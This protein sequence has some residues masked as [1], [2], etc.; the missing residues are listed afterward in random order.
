MSVLS[1]SRGD[2]IRLATTVVGSR[3]VGKPITAG[4]LF[5]ISVLKFPWAG[6]GGFPSI[7]LYCYCFASQGSQEP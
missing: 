6:V 3:N 7:I 4:K 5:S 1:Y 2:M